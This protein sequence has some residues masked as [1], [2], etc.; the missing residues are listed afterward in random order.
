M[1]RQTEVNDAVAVLQQGHGEVER[2]V[3]RLRTFHLVA[4]TQPFHHQLVVSREL[5][6]VD[7][8]LQIHR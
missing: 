7:L 5:A 1:Y 4:Q 2:Q 3:D 8:I 6:L